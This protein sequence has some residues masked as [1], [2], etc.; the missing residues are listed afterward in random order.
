[1]PD[2]RSHTGVVVLRRLLLALLCVWLG[3]VVPATAIEL[4]RGVSLDT[5][6]TWPDDTRLAAPGVLDVFPEWR[7]SIGIEK[8][9]L[10]HEAGFD[11]VRMP[12][13]PYAFLTEPGASQTGHLLQGTL[14]AVAD[15]QKAGL[16]VIVDLHAVPTSDHKVMGTEKYLED[17][18]VFRRYLELVRTFAK[19]LAGSDP[20][21]VAFEPMNEPTR[22]CGWPSLIFKAVWPGLMRQLYDAAR[23]PAPKLP[24]I[25]SGA[26][27][28]GGDSLAR[29]GQGDL[30]PEMLGDRDLIWSFHTYNPYLVSHQGASWAGAPMNAI[31]GIAYPP[32]CEAPSAQDAILDRVDARLAERISDAGK[33]AD[34][35]GQARKLVQ[36]Y[37]APGHAAASLREPFEKV[38]AWAQQMQIPANRL[39][40]GE[41]GM[42]RDDS[43]A[44]A[45]T[46]EQRAAFMHDIRK[47]ADDRG[48]PWAV[49]SH[50]GAFSICTDDESRKVDP[51]FAT[52]LGLPGAGG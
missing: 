24:L 21:S 52:A 25:L 1:M 42:I 19:A 43:P 18:D 17:P 11:F 33:L 27:W 30:T 9:R 23:A 46:R 2:V 47:E 6:E 50:G 8:L 12:I 5:W 4:H 16:K 32:T 26:C 3:P 10:L 39:F 15:I 28:G 29:L 31:S 13:D 20:A 41:F 37:C 48:I 7:R 34:A 51:L 36:Q 22:E 49:W 45:T 14:E 35:S 44:S 40:L 38:M